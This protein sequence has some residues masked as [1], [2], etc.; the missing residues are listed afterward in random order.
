MEKLIKK[1]IKTSSSKILHKLKFVQKAEKIR[2]K[3]LFTLP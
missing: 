2:K 1:Y 3:L